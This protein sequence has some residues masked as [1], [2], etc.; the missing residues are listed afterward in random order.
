MLDFLSM[1]LNVLRS[2][3]SHTRIELQRGRVVLLV[4]S[5]A[6]E[7]SSGPFLDSNRLDSSESNEHSS[8][9]SRRSKGRRIFSGERVNGYYWRLEARNGVEFWFSITFPSKCLQGL[10]GCERPGSAD[11]GEV[12]EQL[13]QPDPLLT[14][15]WWKGEKAMALPPP[16]PLPPPRPTP[17]CPDI[18]SDRKF[19]SCQ[20]FGLHKSEGWMATRDQGDSLCRALSFPMWTHMWVL[21]RDREPKRPNCSYLN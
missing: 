20:S 6:Q 7:T 16:V 19:R 5:W 1:K 10:G 8:E 4:A 13:S 21:A 2:K 14:P 18:S 17:F 11:N 12:V 15:G 9:A 3:F